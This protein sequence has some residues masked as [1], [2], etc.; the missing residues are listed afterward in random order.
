MLA[1]QARVDAARAE[2]STER[3]QRIP[4]VS[5][6]GYVLTE[7]DR[8]AAGGRLGVELPLWSW[9]S[10]R[11]AQ[12]E[13][14]QAT[15]ESRR[16]VAATEIGAAVVEAGAACRQSGSLARRFRDAILPRAERS[17]RTLERSFQ[18]GEATLIEV[19]E[20]RR[21]LL[22]SRR[23]ALAAALEQQLDCSTLVILNGGDLS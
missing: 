19:L 3:R 23:D 10:G 17:A 5:A 12:A 21:V 1:S 7:L 4:S 11:I 6:A 14:N 18:L 8:E 16:L 13:A 22:E 9:N 2:L 15:E 20:S